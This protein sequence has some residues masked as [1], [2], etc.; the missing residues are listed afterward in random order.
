MSKKVLLIVVAVIVIAAGAWL[1]FGR[2]NNNA[3]NGSTANTSS[4]SNTSTANNGQS[5]ANA[6]AT[7]SVSIVNMSFTPADITI[8]K[9]TMVTWTNNDSLTHTVTKDNADT[10]PDS[11]DLTPGAVYRFTYNQVGTFKYHCKFHSD[12]VGS[13]TVTE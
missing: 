3:T 7:N 4:T 8:K 11:S 9:G 1:M 6:T 12:M 2:S 5:A 10:G 13:V